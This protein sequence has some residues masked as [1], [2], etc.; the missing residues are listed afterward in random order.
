M[1]QLVIPVASILLASLD[2][3]LDYPLCDP[4]PL[5]LLPSY[6]FSRRQSWVATWIW[7]PVLVCESRSR[8]VLQWRL[9]SWWCFFLLEQS[10]RTQDEAMTARPATQSSFQLFRQHWEDR[11]G[12]SWSC[13]DALARFVSCS[14]VAGRTA[15]RQRERWWTIS[16][17]TSQVL[18]IS[19]LVKSCLVHGSLH[20]LL[21]ISGSCS[22]PESE[23]ASNFDPPC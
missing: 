10:S 3:D 8:V 15:S 4:L 21:G 12:F 17:C 22:S 1:L 23:V 9:F 5:R 16:S 19:L 13:R 20:H 18:S 6:T 7:S 2:L 11:W 14:S